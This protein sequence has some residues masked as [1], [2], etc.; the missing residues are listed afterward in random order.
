M[1]RWNRG[2]IWLVNLDPTLGSEINKT[3]P[4]PIRSRATRPAAI[5][6]RSDYNQVAE[7][8][9]IIPISSGHF[10]PAFHVPIG[11]LKK[12]SHAVVPQIRVASKRRLFKKIGKVSER[13]MDE[14]V[15]RLGFYLDLA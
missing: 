4:A 2:E 5:L 10:I 7:T 3:R 13:E 9:T 14:I 12:R 6:S 8:V 15:Q 1:N 11:D